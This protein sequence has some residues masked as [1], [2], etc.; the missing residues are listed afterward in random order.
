MKKF[1]FKLE[2]LQKIRKLK[3]QQAI[4]SMAD[5]YR[6]VEEAQGDLLHNREKQQE[7]KDLQDK[8]RVGKIDIHAWKNYN[9]FLQ[10]MRKDEISQIQ[11]VTNEEEILTKK[12]MVVS[13]RTTEKKIVDKMEELQKENYDASLLKYQQKEFDDI[14]SQ[15][16]GRKPKR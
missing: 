12:K 1:E 13:R 14:A 15:R 11:S 8:N 9:M 6:K 5:Q 3:Q 16:F 2:K 7:V 10:N 4:K